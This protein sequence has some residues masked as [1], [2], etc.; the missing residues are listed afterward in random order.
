MTSRQEGGREKGEGEAE[1]SCGANGMQGVLQERHAHLHL[2]ARAPPPLFATLRLRCKGWRGG[3][4]GEHW[5]CRGGACGGLRR[6]ADRM[7]PACGRLHRCRLAGGRML[8]HV[9]LRC[10]NH[11]II[12]QIGLWRE[13]T[14]SA[15]G[16]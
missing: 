15:G 10:G 8:E 2:T 3:G 7:L 13:G 16:S 5:Q 4:S 12:H 14:F 11:M 1:G 6:G 9:G